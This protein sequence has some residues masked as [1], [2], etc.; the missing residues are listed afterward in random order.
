MWTVRLSVQEEKSLL[1]WANDQLAITHWG[2]SGQ[3]MGY[4]SKSA[5]HTEVYSFELNLKIQY[6]NIDW[7]ALSTC[8]K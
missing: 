3:E 5:F 6:M 4:I 1:Q 7:V 8:S 2:H